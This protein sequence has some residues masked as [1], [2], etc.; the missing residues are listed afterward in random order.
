VDAYTTWDWEP[1]CEAVLCF[2]KGTGVDQSVDAWALRPGKTG[3][4]AGNRIRRRKERNP[5][6]ISRFRM[7]STNRIVPRRRESQ[8]LAQ[9][10]ASIRVSRSR[11]LASR[12]S[13]EW[14][15]AP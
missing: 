13:V 11:N 2:A 8:R 3:G 10:P 15:L 4:G 6:R 5:R 7:P 12:N 14:A 1:L 9:R